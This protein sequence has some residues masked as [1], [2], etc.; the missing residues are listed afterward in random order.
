VNLSDKLQIP[1]GRTLFFRNR[2][3]LLDQLRNRTKTK[4]EINPLRRA[5]SLEH[6]LDEVAVDKV[7]RTSLARV[8]HFSKKNSPRSERKR[9]PEARLRTQTIHAS[10]SSNPSTPNSYQTRAKSCPHRDFTPIIS[11]HHCQ[12]K[13]KEYLMTLSEGKR[14]LSF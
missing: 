4:D 13:H 11:K 9:H 1:T 2:D 3:Y 12:F 5:L 8:D 7:R 14:G 10:H 6:K